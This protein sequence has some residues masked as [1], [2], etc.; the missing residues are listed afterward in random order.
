MI[1]TIALI[2][3][4]RYYTIPET[5]CWRNEDIRNLY[6]FYLELNTLLNSNEFDKNSLEYSKEKVIKKYNEL[7]LNKR[8]EGLPNEI[9]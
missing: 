3:V 1:I 6:T 5:V 9:R 2:S 8:I 7:M 4:P